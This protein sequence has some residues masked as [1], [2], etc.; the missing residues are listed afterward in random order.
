M[1]VK[2]DETIGVPAL[3]GT[4]AQNTNNTTTLVAIPYR[5]I[6]RRLMHTSKE[7]VRKACHSAGITLTAK[8]DT[9]CKPYIKGKITNEVGKQAPIEVNILLDFIRIDTVLHK[10]TSHLSHKYSLYIIDV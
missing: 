5:T 3:R 4:P 10:D 2:I 6:Y 8:N 9:F 1:L 7:V